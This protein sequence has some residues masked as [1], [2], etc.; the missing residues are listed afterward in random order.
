MMFFM[1]YFFNSP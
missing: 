1:F